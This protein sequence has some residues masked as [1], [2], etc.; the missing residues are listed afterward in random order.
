MET[1]FKIYLLAL[2]N[3]PKFGFAYDGILDWAYSN[4]K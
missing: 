2:K 1:I 3:P 4:L